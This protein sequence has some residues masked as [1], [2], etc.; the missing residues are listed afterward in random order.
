MNIAL[1]HNLAIFVKNNKACLLV[2]EFFSSEAKVFEKIHQFALFF[3]IRLY[4]RQDRT[5]T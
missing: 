1:L 3:I 5:V 2:L 4:F